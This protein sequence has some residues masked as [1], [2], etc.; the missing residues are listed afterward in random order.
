MKKITADEAKIIDKKA[1][2]KFHIPGLLLMENAGLEVYNRI[3]KII[4]NKRSKIVFFCGRGNNAGD[5]F[6]AIRHLINNGYTNIKVIIIKEDKDFSKEA[7]I[8]YKILTKLTNNIKLIRKKL[9]SKEISREI[10]KCKI[11]VDALLG[12]GLKGKVC[13]N[14]KKAIDI[15]NDS[16]KPVISVDIP[17]GLNATTGEIATSCIKANETLTFGLPKIGCYKNKG[18]KFCGKIRAF[19]IIFPRVLL[20]QG[21]GGDGKKTISEKTIYYQA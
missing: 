18:P 1:Q 9:N 10:K 3:K 8:N 4:A 14:F 16:G 15:I 7:K 13:G 12:I 21:G 2:S 6:V 11:I 19:P 20:K 17:S 5:A